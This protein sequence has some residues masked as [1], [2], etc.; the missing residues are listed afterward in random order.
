M[1][2]KI[3]DSR[4]VRA[5]HAT[6]FIVLIGIISLFADMTYEGARSLHGPFLKTLGAS[7]TAVGII[8]GLGELLGYGLRLASGY[9]SDKTRRYWLIMIAGYALNLLS[10]P[11]LTWAGYWQVAAALMITER[12]GKAVRNPTRDAMLSIAASS[13]RAGWAF[14]LHELLDQT[15][16]TLGP[17]LMMA[18]LAF[19]SDDYRLGYLLLVL[20]ALCAMGALMRAKIVY[21]DPG[22]LDILPPMGASQQ[23]FAP[24][25]YIC[26]IASMC[27]AAGYADFPLI[28][29]HFTRQHIVS[30]LWIPG[31]YALAMLSEGVSSYLSGR[32]FDLWGLWIQVG[33]T[34]VSLFFAPMVFLMSRTWAFAG[35]CIW[36]IGLGAQQ[37]VLKA[38]LSHHTT[39]QKRAY[40]FGL[41]DACY[42]LSWFAGSAFM[43]HLYD[44][45]VVR[46]VTF[47]MNMQT[48]SIVILVAY[49]IKTRR[50]RSE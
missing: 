28:A 7:G 46:L 41:F 2:V 50:K 27:L 24:S 35:M 26:V 42:G 32:L 33:C 39:S 19:R 20:P 14:G 22:R 10:V 25:L 13:T 1:P 49:L 34:V 43:G 18:V 11:L 37:S 6:R 16:A 8:S 9:L 36:G 5:S 29:Y 30:G 44:T 38:F 23:K 4:P 45:S 47:S 17:L 40:A 3:S 48:L 12:I 21:P 15:G 31:L